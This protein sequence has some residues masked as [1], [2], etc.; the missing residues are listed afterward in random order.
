[1]LFSQFVLPSPSLAVS[2]RSFSMF[3]LLMSYIFGTLLKLEH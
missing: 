1:M 2:T 3:L